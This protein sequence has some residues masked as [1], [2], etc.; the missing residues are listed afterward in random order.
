MNLYYSS[1]SGLSMQV[2]CFWWHSS[3]WILHALLDIK[4]DFFCRESKFFVLWLSLRKW[5]CKDFATWGR[6]ILYSSPSNHPSL[7]AEYSGNEK[8][9]HLSVVGLPSPEYSL[10]SIGWMRAVYYLSEGTELHLLTGFPQRRD[11]LPLGYSD[12]E[13]SFNGR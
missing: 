9:A 7:G 1:P 6:R 3:S 13:L 11:A 2:Y 10:Q 8:S 5:L 4:L 12:M